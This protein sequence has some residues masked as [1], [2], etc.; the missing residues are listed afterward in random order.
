M[1]ASRDSKQNSRTGILRRLLRPVARYCLQRTFNLRDLVEEAK[2][3]FVEEGEELLRQSGDKL[4]DS[5][6]AVLTGVHRKD[7]RRI[8]D[9]EKAPPASGKGLVPRV[10]IQWEQHPKFRTAAGKPRV[11]SFDGPGSDFWKLVHSV[12]SEINPA[13]VLFELERGGHAS[14]GARGLTLTSELMLHSGEEQGLEQAALDMAELLGAVR[15]NVTE[16]ADEPNLHLRTEFD[17]IA[18]E[19][20]PKIRHWLLQE[21][22]KFHGRV[23]DYLARYDLDLHPVKNSK[24]GARVTVG[25]FSRTGK[26]K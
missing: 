20:L 15:E 18:P 23:R 21:G 11:L 26:S 10:L 22:S 6:L 17:N 19:A 2:I 13:T 8:L 16:T 4:N 24:G 5:R 7:V 25:A 1:A 3:A 14:R 9:A 12:S